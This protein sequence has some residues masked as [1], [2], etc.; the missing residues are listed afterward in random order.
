MNPAASFRTCSS[1][2]REASNFTLAL[3]S[4]RPKAGLEGFPPLGFVVKAVVVRALVV[5]LLHRHHEGHEP[6]VTCP[7][8]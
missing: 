5:R 7:A 1:S 8:V 4:P 6:G 2:T 3:V